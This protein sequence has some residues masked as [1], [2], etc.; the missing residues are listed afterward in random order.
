MLRFM[1]VT[2]TKIVANRIIG[3]FKEMPYWH[4]V[5]SLRVSE[6]NGLGLLNGISRRFSYVV[7]SPGQENQL[8]HKFFASIC[9]IMLPS[10]K[11]LYTVYYI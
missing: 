1:L 7:K 8:I 4:R 9:I 11:R 2:K 6:F 10:S 3:S 5:R